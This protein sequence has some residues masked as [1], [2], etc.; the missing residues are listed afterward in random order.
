VK[1]E[2]LLCHHLQTGVKASEKLE[3]WFNSQYRVQITCAAIQASYDFFV[4]AQ[5]RQR[6]NTFIFHVGFLGEKKLN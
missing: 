6:N 1:K 4:K 3:C 5:T 2:L